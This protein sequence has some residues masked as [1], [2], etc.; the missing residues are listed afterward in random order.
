MVNVAKPIIGGFYDTLVGAFGS[1]PAWVL[2]HMIILLAG[3]GLVALAKN[4]LTITSGA[5]LGKQQAV[6]ASIFIIA[7][8]IQVQLYSSSAGWPL[9]SSLLIASTF[10]ASLGWCVKVLN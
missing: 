8:G 7:T 1:L 3:L 10:T 2:G 5:K 9:F 4:W 6:E